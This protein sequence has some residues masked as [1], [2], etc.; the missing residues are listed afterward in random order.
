MRTLIVFGTVA[1]LLT[2]AGAGPDTPKKEDVPRLLNVLKTS[3]NAK[4]RVKAAED[5]G[6]VGAIRASYAA[7][8]IDPLIN[9]LAKDKDADVRKAC[10]GALGDI[11]SDADKVVD[12]LTEALKDPSAIVKIAAAGA[13][14]QY[15]PEAKSAL[16]PLRDLAKAKDDKKIS[17]AAAAAVRQIT[18]TA[19][20]KDG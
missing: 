9:A 2:L 5:L 11:G 20:K 18:G 3:T 10:A 12:A 16:P 4:L 17:Q 14:G 6:K 7:D 1:A 13:L 8:A 15:G 19:K